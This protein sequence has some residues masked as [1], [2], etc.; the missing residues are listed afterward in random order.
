LRMRGDV[1]CPQCAKRLP[2]NRRAA[3]SV[4]SMADSAA[5]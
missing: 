4:R 5:Y 2:A 3:A 1:A